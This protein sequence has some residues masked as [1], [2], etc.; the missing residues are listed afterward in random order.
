MAT[1]PSDD[2]TKKPG[3][4]IFAPLGIVAIVVDW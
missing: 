4:V 1:M 2:V 3:I